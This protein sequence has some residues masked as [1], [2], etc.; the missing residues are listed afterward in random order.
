M[1]FHFRKFISLI[2][3]TSWKEIICCPGIM[4]Y[5]FATLVAGS[6][7]DW[8]NAT[9]EPHL[10]EQVHNDYMAESRIWLMEHK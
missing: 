6:S 3:V 7:N 8:F 10:F 4:A 9:M 5:G 2:R 1:A